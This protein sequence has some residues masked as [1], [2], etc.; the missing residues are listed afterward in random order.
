MTN[1]SKQYNATL[2][3][4]T[5]DKPIRMIG[6]IILLLTFGVFGTWSFIAPI[7]SSALATGTVAVKSHR[8]TVQNLDGG[9]ISKLLVKDGDAVKAGDNLLILDDTQI[10]AQLDM[11]GGQFITQ[12]SLSDRLQ[13][14]RDQFR[15]IKFSPE[16]LAM[17]DARVQ[18][19][20]QGQTNIFTS[21]KNSYNGEIKVLQQRIQQLNS[22]IVGLNAQK[23]SKKNL[24][25]SYADE[26]ADLKELLAQGFA[27]K[28]RL[29]DL[30][31]NHT[32]VTGEIAT[33]T[34]DV[35]STQMQRGE[36]E[37]EILQTNKKFQEDVANQQEEVNA[38]LFEITEKLHAVKDKASQTLIKAPVSGLVFNLSIYTEG[39][40]ITPGKPILDIVP[41][42]EDL[43]ISAQVSPLDI[44]RIKIGSIAEVRFTAFNS[45][46]TPTMEGVISKLSADSFVNEANGLQY[47]LATVDLTAESMK[48]LGSLK[49]IPGMPAEVLINTGERT[50]F[51]YLMQPITDAF[52][53][54][55]IEE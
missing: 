18:E 4:E 9:I 37:L 2:S 3:V 46:T 23:D 50:L 47:Y 48:K 6:Y 11:L 42:G 54:S 32:L 33:L 44:D 29:R 26:I 28:Q 30:E 35:A 52:A 5:D 36:T 40:V 20:I 31:R 10:K 17:Q 21:R 12:K 24:V 55:F 16:L 27:D 19:A 7:D 8:K 43:I 34:S 45:K 1:S 15:E 41:E 49:L 51:E 39:G 13:A 38:Q 25:V 14:E 22:K 53:R